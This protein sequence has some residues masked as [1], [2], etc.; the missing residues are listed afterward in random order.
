MYYADNLIKATKEY[1]T[2]VHI[3]DLDEENEFCEEDLDV[4]IEIPQTFHSHS[5]KKRAVNMLVESLEL[6]IFSFRC[7]WL[8]RSCHSAF[9][10]I[11]NSAKKY[12]E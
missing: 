12:C 4:L 7:G 5:N 1:E 8:V 2:M 6:Q 11:F 10:Y 3:D 9:D